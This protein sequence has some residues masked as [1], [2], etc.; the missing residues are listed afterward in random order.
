MSYHD[1]L[2]LRTRERS[3]MASCILLSVLGNSTEALEAIAEGRCL[4]PAPQDIPHR[5]DISYDDG[6]DGWMP[7]GWHAQGL[8]SDG[9]PI[10]WPV[11]HEYGPFLTEDEARSHANAVDAIYA[12]ALQIIEQ[13]K[14]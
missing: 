1:C 8:K 11:R 4:W 14:L 9:F 2:A 5:W 10:D 7:A 12:N 3:S 13:G 6:A